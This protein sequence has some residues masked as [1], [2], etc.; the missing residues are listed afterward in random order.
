MTITE[1]TAWLLSAPLVFLLKTTPFRAWFL[2]I[3]HFVA[4]Y[5]FVAF[6]GPILLEP[7]YYA[8][9]RRSFLIYAGILSFGILLENQPDVDGTYTKTAREK[10]KEGLA[11]SQPNSTRHFQGPYKSVEAS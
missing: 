4:T 6:A 3:T 10:G 1:E 9:L 2:L 11:P 7:S 8:W 5:P